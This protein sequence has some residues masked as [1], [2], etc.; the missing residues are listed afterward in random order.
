MLNL[1]PIQ[2]LKYKKVEAWCLPA[3]PDNNPDFVYTGKKNSCQKP[4]LLEEYIR[5][6]YRFSEKRK[7]EIALKP[8][9]APKDHIFLKLTIRKLNF[10]CRHLEK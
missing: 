4:P 2:K 9:K 3:K 8:I 10:L 5:G 6:G 7:Q 1:F